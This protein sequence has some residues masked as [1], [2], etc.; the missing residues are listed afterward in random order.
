MNRV[1]LDITS[2]TRKPYS[3]SSPTTNPTLIIKVFDDIH[4]HLLNRVMDYEILSFWL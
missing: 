3:T 2:D 1:Y 4:V